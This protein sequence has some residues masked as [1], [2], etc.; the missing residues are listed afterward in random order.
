MLHH[1]A[2][3]HIGSITQAV[4]IHLRGILEETVDQNR[5]VRAGFDRRADVAAEILRRINNLHGAASEHKG[6]THQHRIPHPL[7]HGQG[8]VL[9][10][11]G[12]ALRGVQAEPVQHGGK[13]FAIL[14]H[15][16]AR[17]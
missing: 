11:R 10:G 12:A 9:V 4:H 13:V 16:N 8:L 15:L 2:N 3:D 5:T 1:P 6:R 14:G 7:G 17:R